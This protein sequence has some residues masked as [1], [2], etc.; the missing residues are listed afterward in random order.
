MLRNKVGEKLPQQSQE[1]HWT[2]GLLGA[3]NTVESP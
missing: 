2:L 1:E 3:G